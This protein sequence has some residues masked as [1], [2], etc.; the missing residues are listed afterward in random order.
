MERLIRRVPHANKILIVSLLAGFGIVFNYTYA[1]F[2][3]GHKAGA[4][5]RQR[6][7]YPTEWLGI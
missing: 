7:D 3:Q 2:Q 6:S 5:L 4:P 1:W